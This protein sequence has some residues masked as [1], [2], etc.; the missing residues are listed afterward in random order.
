MF[1][2]KHS[3]FHAANDVKLPAIHAFV[4]IGV[5]A[6]LGHPGHILCKSAGSSDLDLAITDLLEYSNFWLAF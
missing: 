2:L 3:S 6:G 1:R 4:D 5:E